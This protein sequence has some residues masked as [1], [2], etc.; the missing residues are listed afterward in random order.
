LFA[1]PA[2]LLL[3]LTLTRSASPNLNTKRRDT[4]DQSR[5]LFLPVHETG[6]ALSDGAALWHQCA[7]IDFVMRKKLG[8]SW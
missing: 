6:T 1:Q 2:V 4:I 5:A 7:S 3:R 8:Q